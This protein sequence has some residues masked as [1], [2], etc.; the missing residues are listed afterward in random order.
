MEITSRYVQQNLKTI[1]CFMSRRNHFSSIQTEQSDAKQFTVAAKLQSKPS[2]HLPFIKSNVRKCQPL[3]TL[4]SI[5]QPLLGLA[6]SPS[7]M[8][9]TTVSIKNS[10][11]TRSLSV[12]GEGEENYYGE[13]RCD[14]VENG[15][16]TGKKCSKVSVPNANEDDVF[17]KF[18]VSVEKTVIGVNVEIADFDAVKSRER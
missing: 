9:P 15:E 18:F 1:S 3:I 13:Y 7:M 6:K 12:P 17:N 10:F 16:V 4:K 2:V 14:D 5:N 8:A 11:L